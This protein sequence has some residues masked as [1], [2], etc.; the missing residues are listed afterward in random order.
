ML[1]KINAAIL[2]TFSSP[3]PNQQITGSVDVI[4][5]VSSTYQ[6]QFLKAR[7][8]T[9]EINLSPENDFYRGTLSLTGLP[10]DT[11]TLVVTAKDILQNTDSSIIKIIN[12]P[13]DSVPQF[14]LLFVPPLT[15]NV[16][17]PIHI[18]ARDAEGDVRINVIGPEPDY[19]P[20]IEGINEID[21]VID[22]SHIAKLGAN[23]TVIRV[24]GT[25]TANHVVTEYLPFTFEPSPYL[26]KFL[27]YKV[28]D[29][30]YNKILKLV[31]NSYQYLDRANGDSI[32]IPTSDGEVKLT[33]VGY[34]QDQAGRVAIYTPDSLF[35]KGT[36]SKGIAVAGNYIVYNND[37][38]VISRHN[39]KTGAIDSIDTKS[40]QVGDPSFPTN[41]V[42]KDWTVDTTGNVGL[43]IYW[44]DDDTFQGRRFE[45]R[46]NDQ[47]YASSNLGVYSLILKGDKAVVNTAS[48]DEIGQYFEPW[49]LRK[50][51]VEN[52]TLS[53]EV[54][55]T[56]DNRRDTYSYDGQYFFEGSHIAYDKTSDG[57]VW[58]A[59][60][61]GNKQ[62]VGP[63]KLTALNSGGEILYN[64]AF[65][66]SPPNGQI[67]EINHTAA[68]AFYENNNW[69]I[70]S[71]ELFKLNLGAQVTVSDIVRDVL[72]DSSYTFTAK[73][74]DDAA[75]VPYEV[76]IT[77]LPKHGTL[78]L[79]DRP[80]PK[81]SLL[82]HAWLSK[83]V[84]VPDD[85]FEGDDTAYWNANS[86]V[87][88]APADARLVFKVLIVLPVKLTEFT[89]YSK[90]A[91]N[92][93]AW[94][95]AEE[96][97]TAS[98]E[99]QR[100]SQDSP[101]KL[102]AKLN[103]AG[104]SSVMKEYTYTDARPG[105]GTNFYR[106]K[107]IDKD[108]KY[109]FSPIIKL[110]NSDEGFAAVVYPNPAADRLFLRFNVPVAQEVSVTISAI[111]G[112]PLIS[113]R[114]SIAAGSADKTMNISS[115]AAGTYFI[116]ITGNT[117]RKPVSF[118]FVKK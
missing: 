84:Y 61:G 13:V 4:V 86:T 55:D 90:G 66:F 30:R 96:K 50:A 97:N 102:L 37:K 67:I 82:K 113:S 71:V 109:S 28:L 26:E 60:W 70:N 63:G 110:E 65:M 85:S 45:L 69:Y 21:T 42:V 114:L 33:A 104:N 88:F 117:K 80:L 77:A 3:S 112:N 24:L 11:L 32:L 98:F 57:T 52:G 105:A 54:I 68:N 46:V 12:K 92:V 95:T 87:G 58:R 47:K 108:G 35:Y 78:Y 16:Y 107:V 7:I 99:L 100:S 72:K 118:K 29:F 18:K 20:L 74:F 15:Q 93:L 27:P 38:Q 5:S 81:D 14:E 17:L 56:L 53:V 73:D 39:L 101:F 49:I 116:T 25:D 48:N 23:A 2:I 75:T 79:N 103:A 64:A 51:G 34:I 22:I 76:K 91:A 94:K 62:K 40:R 6:L 31:G 41:F 106:L 59:D 9:S 19:Y 111:N 115:L 1:I 44:W 36:G 43:S 89:G 10:Y 83:L 8:L